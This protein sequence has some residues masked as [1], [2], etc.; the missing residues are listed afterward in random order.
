MPDH[1]DAEALADRAA[2]LIKPEMLGQLRL[3]VNEVGEE[4]IA[5]LAIDRC[6]QTVDRGTDQER[7]GLMQK[8]NGGVDRDQHLGTGRGVREQQHRNAPLPSNQL[9]TIGQVRMAV[10]TRNEIGGAGEAE[11]RTGLK[12][13]RGKR[14]R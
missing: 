8:P 4:A 1:L 9:Y 14:A 6:A 5:I 7:L 12:L 13:G 11:S 3:A 2:A 10:I